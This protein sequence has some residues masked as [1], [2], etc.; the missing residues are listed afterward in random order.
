MG[1]VM[2]KATNITWHQ[3]TIG[4]EE[5]EERNGHKG[6]VVWLTGLSASGKT[7]IAL[8]SEKILFDKGYNVY[9]L[10]G[11]NIRHG[12]NKD[13]GFSPEDREENIRRISEVSK[14]FREGG[15]IVFTAFISPYRKDRNFGRSIVDEGHFC[16]VF[17][18]C[19]LDGCINRDPR[20]LYKK[21]IDGQILEFTGISA[22]YE[23]PENPELVI[24]TE[25]FNIEQS[26]LK[27]VEKLIEMK[28]IEK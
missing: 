18:K 19:S 24:D 2:I 21:A 11:D 6:C 13:L 23:E 14:L 12:L 3:A 1:N 4:T 28:I 16:E 7:T 10:D 26:A 17:V 9:L 5:I 27:V 22:P 15:F 8:A 20:G 25:E